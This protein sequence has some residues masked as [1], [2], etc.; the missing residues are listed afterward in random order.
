MP[1]TP[2][3]KGTKVPKLKR[4]PITGWDEQGNFTITI[5]VNKT[6]RLSP[7][8]KCYMF[9]F[10]HGELDTEVEIDGVRR[11]VRMTFMLYAKVPATERRA[12]LER[13]A[14]LLE[15][16]GDPQLF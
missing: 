3:P 2:T 16:Q 7:S 8:K 13:Q 1:H 11:K 6:P 14:K 4:L 9:A 10:E 5:Q 15:E 12:N